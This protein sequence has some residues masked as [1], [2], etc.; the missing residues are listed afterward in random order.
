MRTNVLLST[1]LCIL[2]SNSLFS[3]TCAIAELVNAIPYSYT[4]TTIGAGNNYSQGQMCGSIYGTGND[5]VFEYTST[6]NE[7]IGIELEN[8][9]DDRHGVFVFDGCPDVGTTQC[10]YQAFGN[11][12]SAFIETAYLVNAGTYYIIVSSY[13]ALT[14]AYDFEISITSIVGN[15]CENAESIPSIPFNYTGTTV[16][17]GNDYSQGQMC[18]SLNGTGND[19]VFEYAST[20]NEVLGIELENLNDDRHGVFVFDGCPDDASTLCL[21]EFEAGGIDSAFIETAHLVTAGT[22][23]IIVSSYGALTMTYDFELSITLPI[24]NICENAEIIPSIPFNY[25]GTTVG[26]GDDY[27]QGEM[28]GS[29]YGRGN[30]FVFEYTS[31]GD[32][33]IGIELENLNED[34]HGV[35]VFDGCPDDASTL[36]LFQEVSGG[37]D[38]AFIETAYL[39]NPGT[40]Y[41]IVSSYGELTINYDF[42]LNITSPI[43]NICENARQITSFPYSF[44]GTT[45]ESGNDYQQGQMC[46]SLYG[47][48]RDYVFEY[49][50]LGN[51]YLSM[52][53]TNLNDDQYGLFV[54]EDCPDDMTSTC[55]AFDV[56]SNSSPINLNTSGCLTAGT[57]YY[58]IASSYRE[59]TDW[60]DFTLDIT[61]NLQV[62][63]SGA[64]TSGLLNDN[65]LCANEAGTAIATISA[66]A[67][68][69]NGGGY[70]YAWDNA[71]NSTTAM[72][73]EIPG[74]SSTY[75]VTATDSG[76][77]SVVNAY[78]IAVDPT[79]TP[80]ITSSES[81]GNSNDNI[82][83]S[84]DAGSANINLD[85]SSSSGGF[86]SFNYAWNIGLNTAIINQSPSS[87]FTYYVTVTDEHGCTEVANEM[88]SINPALSVTMDAAG[89]SGTPNDFVFCNYTS[90]SQATLIANVNGG[91]PTYTYDWSPQNG[92][93]VILLTNPNVTTAFTINV[94]DAVGCTA[95]ATETLF[96][97]NNPIIWTGPT[98]RNWYD[99]PNYWSLGRFPSVCDHVT[100]PSGKLVT[101]RAGYHAWAN[102]LEVE[103]QFDAKDGSEIDVVAQQ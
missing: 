20:G 82:I 87:N 30:D 55:Y 51:E 48:G 46:S 74:S 84:E 26:S 44:T 90:G 72:I 19:F 14:M 70:S 42:E 95:S 91:T 59:V 68:G 89:N 25:I 10:L 45:R 88:F 37:V 31:D 78:T 33:V 73:S 63:V 99:N 58:I 38:S 8:L 80:S 67:S 83:C 39:M 92:S 2:L 21:Y 5:F 16:G 85:A 86:G 6:G 35:F 75:T 1:G 12:D 27:S 94:E 81:S 64:E 98:N 47:R 18:S 13:G 17:S 56:K 24:G 62:A 29:L 103:G 4:G 60:Y 50:P 22:Y 49:T 28:C 79:L 36:C 41:I 32:E 54:F 52:T 43:G 71:S 40:Y 97:P 101:L 69:G 77:C 57:T 7:V 65:Y 34:F 96:V 100:I 23:Y 66:S 76:G 93:N 15:I 102:T 11:L 61:Q 9:N 53:L 3:N